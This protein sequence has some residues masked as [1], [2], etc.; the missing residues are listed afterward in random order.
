VPVSSGGK[1]GMGPTMAA[2]RWPAPE[3]YPAWADKNV[4]VIVIIERPAAIER[5][6]EIAAVPGIDVLFIGLNDLSYGYGVPAS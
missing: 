5:I 2:L 3:G 1:R 6:E 4:M